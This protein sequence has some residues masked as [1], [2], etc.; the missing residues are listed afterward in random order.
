[1][2]L[3]PGS[4]GFP[5]AS[6]DRRFYAFVVDR[7]IGWGLDAVA[8]LAAWWLFFED[9]RIWPGVGLVVGVVLLVGV[10]FS[11][12]VGT[13]GLTPGKA[14]L[15]LR[16]V[17]HDT[18]ATIGTGRALVRT[19]VLGIAGLPT[20]G[21]GV[22]TLAQTA[23]V[24]PERQRRGWHDRV[25][26]AT[27]IDINPP[28]ETGP[29]VEVRPQQVVNLTAMRLVPAEAR[30]TPPISQ[31]PIS[32]APTSRAPISQAPASRAPRRT[33]PAPP[34]RPRR[35]DRGSAPR[36]AVPSSAPG[37]S[38]SPAPAAPVPPP[39]G[40]LASTGPVPAPAATLPV[41][42]APPAPPAPAT[43]PA[44][45]SSSQAERTVVRSGNQASKHRPA[46][47]RVTFDTGESMLVEG[48]A[49][50]GRRP[51]GRPGEPVRHLVPLPSKDMSLSKT[52]AQFQVAGDGT[53]VVMDRGSTN[54]STLVRSGVSRELPP[55]KPTSLLPGDEVRFGDHSMTVAKEQ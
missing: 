37:A 33:P 1:M 9:G 55:G 35:P 11:V 50:V 29:A 26:H 23:L 6:F 22:A 40:R 7:A 54:G 36:P 17:D 19:L 10:V 47:W 45:P 15:G 52:H 5:P 38:G 16:V 28:P 46:Q 48:L 4:E 43:R 51:E 12:L 30:P 34:S 24:D 25:S 8:V 39:P 32:Q 44:P 18:G 3:A 41:P 21:L 13:L 31:A 27:V 53:L 14:L 20:A 49:L 2:P 42:A